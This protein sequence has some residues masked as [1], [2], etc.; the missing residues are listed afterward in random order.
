[1]N[2]Q[3]IIDTVLKKKGQFGCVIL[4]KPLKTRKGVTSTVSKI[5]QI[6]I[7]AGINYDNLAKVKEKRETGELPS[8]NQGLAWGTWEHYPYIIS[9]NDKKYIRLYPSGKPKEQYFVDKAPVCVNS[10]KELVLAS[11]LPK[12]EIPD[13]MTV[14]IDSIEDIS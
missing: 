11:E 7:R 14:C 13:C 1:M 6:T 8:I 10:I 12:E 2:T 9:H 5:S 4:N 3:A